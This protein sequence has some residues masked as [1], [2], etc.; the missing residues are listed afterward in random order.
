MKIYNLKKDSEFYKKLLNTESEVSVLIEKYFLSDIKGYQEY[1]SLK[2]I[3]QLRSLDEYKFDFLAF[4]VIIQNNNFRMNPLLIPVFYLLKYLFI[5]RQ[6]IKIIKP[7]VD[8]IRAI[9]FTIFLFNSKKDDRKLTY[10]KIKTILLYLEATGEYKEEVKRF[11][12]LSNFI[13]EMNKSNEQELIKRIENSYKEFIS[14]CEKSL[15]DYLMGVDSFIKN[16]RRDYLWREDLLFCFRP[17][18]EYYLNLVG[19]E[20][21]NQAFSESF[22]I[23][24][25][26]ALLL[27][28]CARIFQNNNCKAKKHSLDF[29][30]SECNANCKIGYYTRLGKELNFSVHIIPH[31]SDFSK[32]LKTWAAGRNIGVIGVACPLNLIQGGLE[33]RALEI[34]AQCVFLDY[35]GC[36]NHWYD[37][38]ISTDIN[39]QR[40]REI[41]NKN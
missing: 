5:I 39:E 10:R 13:T 31:S 40:L 9:L 24:E 21:L 36:S 12:G 11:S 30:C 33:L 7:F 3:E 38:P 32:W 27:S 23:T 14:I 20:M 22:L 26:K 8:R 4:V 19:S 25:R 37:K 41:I 6:N 1:I 35:C 16:K 34:P 28:A 2:G 18:S 15:D 29:V 17:K